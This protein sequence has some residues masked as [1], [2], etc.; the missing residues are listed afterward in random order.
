MKQKV[1]PWGWEI[2]SWYISHIVTVVT[3]LKEVLKYIAPNYVSC[4]KNLSIEVKPK[5]SFN[6]HGRSI[7][8]SRYRSRV[9]ARKEIDKFCSLN[10]NHGAIRKGSGLVLKCWCGERCLSENCHTGHPCSIHACFGWSKIS[11]LVLISDIRC[12]IEWFLRNNFKR[13]STKFFKGVLYKP[14]KT[15]VVILLQNCAK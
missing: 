4:Q 13:N 6:R 10:G 1:R 14:T 8:L 3:N 5:Q 9:P 2:N 11:R 7:Y 12:Y 15:M